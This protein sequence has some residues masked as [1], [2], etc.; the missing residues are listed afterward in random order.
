[1]TWPR[2]HAH[3]LHSTSNLSPWPTHT[4]TQKFLLQTTLCVEKQA[5][6][7]VTILS[8][9]TVLDLQN[10]STTTKDLN[11]QRLFGVF[12]WFYS[13]CDGW[14][15]RIFTSSPA[16]ALAVAVVC[17]LSYCVAASGARTNLKVWGHTPGE[18]SQKKFLLPLHFFGSTSTITCSRFGER[19]R[20]G[21]Y[22]LDSYCLLFFY[23]RYPRAQPFVKVA[24]RAPCGRA[25]L[26]RRR[27]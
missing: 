5:L 8:H 7:T 21:Q 18:K 2:W 25:L 3:L 26:S 22:S 14:L 10:S 19:F 16:V 17:K 15:L 12:Q 11:L 23:T 24:A 20:D 27:W 1:V 13:S 9:P 4:V 6:V